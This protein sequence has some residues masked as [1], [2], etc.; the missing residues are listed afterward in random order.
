MKRI[1]GR[2]DTVGWGGAMALVPLFPTRE[3]ALSLFSDYVSPKRCRVGD[4]GRGV[5]LPLLFGAPQ[6]ASRSRR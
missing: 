3:L 6:R 1:L 5:D 4:L 2:F